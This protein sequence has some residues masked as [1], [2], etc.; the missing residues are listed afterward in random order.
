MR[1]SED[2]TQRHGMKVYPA[3][4]EMNYIVI[5]TFLVKLDDV[6]VIPNVI[7]LTVLIAQMTFVMNK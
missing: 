5:H 7:A 1:H 4:L 6:P 2:A 3:R